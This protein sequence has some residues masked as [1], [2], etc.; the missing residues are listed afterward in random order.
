MGFTG[1]AI[2]QVLNSRLLTAAT[3]VRSYVMSAL[4]CGGQS[5]T[6]AGFL[7]VILFPLQILIPSNASELLIMLSPMLH[8][9]DTDSALKKLP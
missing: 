3:S 7:L 5:G 9:L 2:A 8:N 4:V 6:W 1:G